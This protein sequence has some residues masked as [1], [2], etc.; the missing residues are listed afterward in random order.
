MADR[1]LAILALAVVLVEACSGTSSPPPSAPVPTPGPP[2]ASAPASAPSS[3]IPSAAGPNQSLLGTAFKPPTEVTPG[4]TLIVG[5]Y[6]T[7]AADLNPFYTLTLSNVEAISPVLRGLVTVT[8]DG[9]YI[10]DLAEHVPSIENGDVV[11]SGKTF[12]VKVTLRQNLKWSDGSAL[13]LIDFKAT[14]AWANDPGQIGCPVCSSGWNEIDAI[15]ID[16]TGLTAT[17]HFKDLYAGWLSFLTNLFFQSAWLK[18]VP[19]ADGPKS[20]PATAAIA[21]VPF[22]GPFKI[23]NATNTEID[24]ERNPEWNAG[25]DLA[26]GGP[27]HPAYLDGLK[28]L[29]FPTKDGEIDA[30]KTG[31]IDLA[32]NLNQADAPAMATTD[33][34]IG[35]SALEPVWQY[36]HLDLNN[37]PSHARG[38]GLWLPDVRTALAMAIDKADLLGALFPGQAIQPACTPTPDSVWYRKAET[39]PAFDVAGANALLD[40]AGLT[41]GPDGLRTLA[42][43]VVDLE[44]CTLSGNPTRLTILQKVQGYLAAIGFKSRLVTVDASS[45]LF[46]GW[47]D[48]KP[49]TDCSIYR[50]TYDIA[51]FAYVISADPYSNYYYTYDSSQFPEVGDHSG[52]NDTRFSDPAMDAALR[53]LGS[54]VEISKQLADAGAL[55]DAYNAGIPE[56]PLYFSSAAV[57]RS[58]HFGGWPGYNPTAAG[59]TWETEDWFFKP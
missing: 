43:K 51:D 11:I 47:T 42:G 32:L 48:T 33:P 25:V 23:T 7:G 4:G 19:P 46:A 58:V 10:P 36:E 21:A 52:T 20:M 28:F 56:I 57:G 2:S 53:A 55:Q 9:K 44:L 17:L 8:S 3:P 5:A 59:P 30:F 29:T 35:T 18:G 15:D 54:D 26:V 1:R 50:G 38:N 40:S 31:A 14:W 34:S 12:T 37:D 39:C 49:D 41:R 27:S 22:D 6:A 16:S 24:Y 13:T 45:V